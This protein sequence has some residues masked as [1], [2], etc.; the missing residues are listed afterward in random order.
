MGGEEEGFVLRDIGFQ[1]FAGLLLEGPVGHAH[2]LVEQK[3]IGRLHR[4][5]GELQPALHARRIGAEGHVEK[6][7]EI[8]EFLD[9]GDEFLDRHSGDVEQTVAQLG[10]LAAGQRGIGAAADGQKR[11]HRAPNLDRA[12]CDRHQ[13]GND[14][15]QRRLAVAVATDNAYP[16]AAAHR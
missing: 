14:L 8:G 7:A 12:A 15:E 1:P 2:P 6:G 10:V 11:A 5:Q 16:L 9:I 13:S 4:V 3:N